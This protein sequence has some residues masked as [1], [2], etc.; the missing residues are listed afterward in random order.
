MSGTRR[1]RLREATRDEIKTI[2]RQQMA[3]HGTAGITLRGIAREMEIT[4]TALYRYFAS[5]DDLLTELILDGYNAQADA[6]E[7]V[8][9]AQAPDDYAGQMFAALLTY[10]QWALDHRTDFELLYGNPIPGYVAPAERTTPAASRNMEVLI[11]VM[12]GAVTARQMQTTGISIPPTVAAHLQ[13]ANWYGA[14]PELL[15]LGTIG[16]S[17]IH[18]LIMLELFEHTPPVIGDSTAFYR[19]QV[20]HLMRDMGLPLPPDHP[21]AT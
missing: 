7:A 20:L 1:E 15:Y 6:M 3:A 18:G 2:A 11:R 13:A 10:R 4:A 21:L 8:V 9:S 16:W 12:V 17:R 5:R 19:D 14:P